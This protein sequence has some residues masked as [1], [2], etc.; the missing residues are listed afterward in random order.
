M[1]LRLQKVFYACFYSICLQVTYCRRR[2]GS[3]SEKDP[4]L[5]INVE[6]PSNGTITS[7]KEIAISAEPTDRHTG[8]ST[9]F[10]YVTH[11]HHQNNQNCDLNRVQYTV[12][13]IHREY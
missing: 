12:Y 3:I 9:L 10:F 4:L 8:M 13:Y 1:N 5:K 2:K 7:E 11:H 6:T